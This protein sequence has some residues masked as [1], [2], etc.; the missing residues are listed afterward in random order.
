[1]KELEEILDKQK[2]NKH[3]IKI[4][5]LREFIEN[6]PNDSELGRKVREYFLKNK[7]KREGLL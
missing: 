5:L 3:I 6:N 7:L 4:S 2:E 1:M